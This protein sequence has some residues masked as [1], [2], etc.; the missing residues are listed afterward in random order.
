VVLVAAQ[1]LAG[2]LPLDL[3]VHLRAS[4]GI[5]SGQPLDEPEV[6]VA[7]VLVLHALDVAAGLAMESH[8]CSALRR[9]RFGSF[10]AV[11]PA[12]GRDSCRALPVASRRGVRLGATLL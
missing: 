1:G 10:V 2:I 9:W 5:R 3:T 4:D 12:L 6:D 7:E 8:W 11:Q